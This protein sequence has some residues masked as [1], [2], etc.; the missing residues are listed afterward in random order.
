MSDIRKKFP[1]MEHPF[2]ADFR[3]NW[4]SFY[5]ECDALGQLSNDLW[6][7]CGLSAL[8]YLRCSVEVQK[9]HSNNSAQI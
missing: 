4:L 8:S 5:Y 9:F 2:W 1:G 6:I 3:S 7:R